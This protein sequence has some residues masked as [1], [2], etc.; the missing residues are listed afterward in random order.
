LLVRDLSFVSDAD[1]KRLNDSV[2]EVKRMLAALVR[3]VEAER[4]A[5]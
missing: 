2:V 1:Y 5:G 4:R 3:T